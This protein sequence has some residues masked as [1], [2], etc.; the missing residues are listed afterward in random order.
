MDG[1]DRSMQDRRK[2]GLWNGW[3]GSIDEGQKEGRFM[4]WMEGTRMDEGQKEGR[5]M[6][7][8][9]GSMMK[10]RRQEVQEW[11][12]GSIHEGWKEG[13]GMDGMDGR[14]LEW[15]KDRRKEGLWNGWKDR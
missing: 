1:R 5:F 7:W 11:M 15:M 14:D 8:M 12:E 3:K 13:L 6:E 2:D 9:E 10:D 4:E